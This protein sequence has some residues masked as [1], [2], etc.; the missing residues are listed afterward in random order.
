MTAAAIKAVC[1]SDRAKAVVTVCPGTTA[2]A[3][4]ASAARSPG[5]WGRE[6]RGARRAG[7]LLGIGRAETRGGALARRQASASAARRRRTPGETHTLAGRPD[8]MGNPRDQAQRLVLFMS[9]GT[10][11]RD[12][13]RARAWI[14]S[15]GFTQHHHEPAPRPTASRR[16]DVGD[17]PGRSRCASA[18]SDA[19]ARG[20]PLLVDRLEHTSSRRTLNKRRHR[21]RPPRFRR[22]G[23]FDGVRATEDLTAAAAGGWF[24]EFAPPIG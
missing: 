3:G 17:G 10:S 11:W 12:F 19:A 15:A 22:A 6:C 21:R 7:G 9:D 18:A 16:I 20:Q 4:R 1:R 2:A 24:G 23:L 8:G 13:P 14:S 5:P